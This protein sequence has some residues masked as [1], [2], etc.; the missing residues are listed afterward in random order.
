[1]VSRDGFD[2]LEKFLSW[3]FRLKTEGGAGVDVLCVWP[4]G[5]VEP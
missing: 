2:E 1:M 5:G 4:R 3:A